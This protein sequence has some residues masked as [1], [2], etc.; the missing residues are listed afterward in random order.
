MFDESLNHQLLLIYKHQKS[1]I[2]IPEAVAPEHAVS[3]GSLFLNLSV[4]QDANIT[5]NYISTQELN[6]PLFLLVMDS[7]RLSLDELGG[8]YSHGG[9]FP[10]SLRINVGERFSRNHT[11]HGKIGSILYITASRLDLT[12][13]YMH[14]S[15]GLWYQ[16]I[17]SFALTAFEM[18]NSCS[19]S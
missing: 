7:I 17:C 15:P 3:T 10:I 14:V 13:C 19:L 8:R 4:D 1:L 2:L 18:R 12:S 6:S 11:I 9:E 16:K 5:I